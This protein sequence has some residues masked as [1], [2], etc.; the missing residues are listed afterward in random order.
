MSSEAPTDIINNTQGDEEEG[1]GVVMA[2]RVHSGSSLIL[3]P[4]GDEQ[5]DEETGL[6]S[7]KLLVT[8]VKKAPHFRDRVWESYNTSTR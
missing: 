2:N 5:L 8:K 1:G 7:K 4:E 6:P 3:N